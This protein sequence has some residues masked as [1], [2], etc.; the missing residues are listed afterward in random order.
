MREDTARNPAPAANPAPVRLPPRPTRLIGRE[1]EVATLHELLLR[2]DVRLVTV[3][4]PPGC[5]QDAPGD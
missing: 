2:G 3:T 5:R 1:R 4:G